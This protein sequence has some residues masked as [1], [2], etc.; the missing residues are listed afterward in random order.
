MKADAMKQKIKGKYQKAAGELQE[1]FGDATGDV[2]MKVKG[3]ISKA[4]GTYNESMADLKTKM[5]DTNRDYSKDIDETEP[6][7]DIDEE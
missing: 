5:G 6:L 1:K 2:K 4:K 3:G 7:I